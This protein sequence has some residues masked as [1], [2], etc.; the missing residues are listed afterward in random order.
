MRRQEKHA[1]WL[2]IN[3]ICMIIFIFSKKRF[4]MTS[5]NNASFSLFLSLAWAPRALYSGSNWVNYLVKIQSS[6]N[7]RCFQ[8]VMFDMK[9]KWLLFKLVNDTISITLRGGQ[10]LM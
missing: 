4:E 5:Q 10:Y 3:H 2:P 7:I 1:I 6:I 9:I 8:L